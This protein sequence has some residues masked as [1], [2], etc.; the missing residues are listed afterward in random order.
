MSLSAYCTR[1]LNCR[2]LLVQLPWWD[3]GPVY[4]EVGDPRCGGSPHLS[5][6][7]DQIKMRDYMDRR[8]TTPK[9]VTSPTWGPHLYVK[10]PFK[11]YSCYRAKATEVRWQHCR[12][13]ALYFLDLWSFPNHP[14]RLLMVGT[15]FCY[16]SKHFKPCTSICTMTFKIIVSCHYVR[17]F[18]TN[19]NFVVPAQAEYSYFSVDFRGKKYSWTILKL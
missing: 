15:I 10:R 12:H 8:V 17:P 7:R 6:K 5:C 16:R 2:L 3:L 19:R 4:M 11:K 18:F 1:N 9:R 13:E 14:K